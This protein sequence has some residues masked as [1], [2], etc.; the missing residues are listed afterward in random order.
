ML[1]VRWDSTYQEV[2]QPRHFLPRTPMTA[3]TPSR[4][5]LQE[6]CNRSLAQGQEG[7]PA[8]L[9]VGTVVSAARSCSGH[10][11]RVPVG[12]RASELPQAGQDNK[13]SC[14]HLSSDVPATQHRT[15]VRG[16][17]TMGERGGELESIHGQDH[18][19]LPLLSQTSH[20]L[21][22]LCPLN[23]VI[24]LGPKPNTAHL[25]D[26]GSPSARAALPALLQ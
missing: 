18:C 19:G 22:T 2:A 10:S 4:S 13:Q 21:R 26:T 3:G 25:G 15:A 17:D 11:W 20:H 1:A 7:A 8:L 12:H 16:P 24:A 14:V 23:P 9:L 6:N 5:S